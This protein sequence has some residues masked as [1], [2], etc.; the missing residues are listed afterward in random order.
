MRTRGRRRKEEAR[1]GKIERALGREGVRRQRG[2][3]SGGGGGGG[4][5]GGEGGKNYAAENLLMM[6]ETKRGRKAQGRVG[7]LKA[8]SRKFEAKLQYDTPQPNP[9][10]RY[11]GPQR[12]STS[13][14][15]HSNQYHQDHSTTR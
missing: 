10:G 11:G 1:R 7:Q 12:E 9:T 8:G 4:G 6:R 15:V 2:G 5:G 3:S 13:R 14:N